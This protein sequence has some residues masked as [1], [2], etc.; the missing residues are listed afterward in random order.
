MFITNW[1]AVGVGNYGLVFPDKITSTQTQI[2]GNVHGHPNFENGE[3]VRTA[4]VK[5]YICSPNISITTIAGELFD[6]K[7]REPDVYVKYLEAREN[8]SLTIVKY[9]KVINGQIAG[10]TLDGARISGRVVRQNLKDNICEFD[11]GRLVFVDWLSRDEGFVLNPVP[12]EFL[13]FGIERCMPDIL[14]KHFGMFRKN[15]D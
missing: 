4:V 10:K 13:V 11:N 3:Y 15:N 9:W 1:L 5:S 8:K 2:Y 7:N 14:G 12:D 6:L